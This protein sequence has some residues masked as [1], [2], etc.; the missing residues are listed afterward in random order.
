V[1]TERGR[2]NIER[3]ASAPAA[4]LACDLSI[5]I[6]LREEG[7]IERLRRS[8]IRPI[9]ALPDGVRVTFTAES[10]EPVARYIEVESQCCPFLDLSAERRAGGVLLS[11]TGRPEAQD[12]IR[13]I[14]V[15]PERPPG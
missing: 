4:D 2:R 14:F 8:I 10:W 3:P 13:A 15:P 7:V 6:T 1:T 12:L 5:A 11:V 9:E